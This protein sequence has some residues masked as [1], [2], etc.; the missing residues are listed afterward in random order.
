MP[1]RPRSTQ[2]TG[3]RSSWP[4]RAADRRIPTP[5]AVSPMSSSRPRPTTCPWITSTEP[6]SAPPKQRPEISVSPH[7]RHTA[8]AELRWSSTCCRTTPTVLPPTS[9][10]PSTSAAARLRSRDPS[11]SCTIVRARWRSPRLRLTKRRCWNW[12]SRLTL[13]TLQSLRC[14]TL[15]CVGLGCVLKLDDGDC[16]PISLCTCMRMCMCMRFVFIIAWCGIAA[17]SYIPTRLSPCSWIM[18]IDCLWLR[19]I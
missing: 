3:R 16:A 19:A 13:K 12:P 15:R 11:S 9:S 10:P 4:S 2:S 17:Y 7:S 1:R 8:S 5:T 6:S 18:D 14:V